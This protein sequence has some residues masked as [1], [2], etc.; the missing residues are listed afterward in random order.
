MTVEVHFLMWG[1]NLKCHHEI[2]WV[3][4][5][6]PSLPLETQPEGLPNS[7]GHLAVPRGPSLLMAPRDRSARSR[8]KSRAG[9]HVH[10][11]QI[12]NKIENSWDTK[13][14]NLS[15][16]EAMCWFWVH[17]GVGAF[18]LRRMWSHESGRDN[19]VSH[20]EFF[21]LHIWFEFGSVRQALISFKVLSCR[22][23]GRKSRCTYFK[24]N[25]ITRLESFHHICVGVRVSES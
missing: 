19:I 24:C 8:R 17:E 22:Y 21:D 9:M 15:V 23:L 5:G 16:K 2:E 1:E 18:S 6:L 20:F 3:E 11:R 13:S 4:K 10:E 14:M 25:C 12:Y 7:L